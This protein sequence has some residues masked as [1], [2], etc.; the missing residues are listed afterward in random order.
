MVGTGRIEL[1]TSSVSRKR[2][3][4]ELR[5]CKTEQEWP[6][7][8]DLAST[9]RI[10]WALHRDQTTTDLN[11]ARDRF[12][13]QFFPGVSTRRRDRGGFILQPDQSSIKILATRHHGGDSGR[14]DKRIQKW[15]AKYCGVIE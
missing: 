5:A 1:P 12:Y 10:T 15:R 7:R 14:P 9:K 4:T 3:P 11:S 6:E 2:S 8:V 13:Y